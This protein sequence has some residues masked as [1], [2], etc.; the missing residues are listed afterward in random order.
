MEF[1]LSLVLGRGTALTNSALQA[2]QQFLGMS[3]VSLRRVSSSLPYPL[4]TD[5]G[6]GF[7]IFLLPL[8]LLAGPRCREVTGKVN[9][10]T[11]TGRK[12][13]FVFFSA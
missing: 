3:S 13:F 6:C 7:L 4:W 10:C 1:F 2:F 8:L 11:G 12:A 9:F 5:P